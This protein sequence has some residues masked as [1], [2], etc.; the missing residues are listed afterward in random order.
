MIHD[1]P[2]DLFYS[3]PRPLP[4]PQSFLKRL[5]EMEEREFSVFLKVFLKEKQRRIDALNACSGK[6]KKRKSRKFTAQPL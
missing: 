5:R 2:D 1:N 3:Q 4:L 6:R